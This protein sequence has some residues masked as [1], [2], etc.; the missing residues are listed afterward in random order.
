MNRARSS[1]L[2]VGSALIVAACTGSQSGAPA[3][4][5]TEAP[6]STTSLQAPPKPAPAQYNNDRDKVS[7]D[8]CFELSDEVVTELGYDA[9][10]RDRSD[11]LSNHYAFIG[12]NFD[13]R[14]DVRGQ[15]LVTGSLT[16]HASNITLPE[17]RERE[18]RNAENIRIGARD[19]IRYPAT[20]TCYVVV[21]F[22]EGVLSVQ[23][24]TSTVFVSENPCDRVLPAAEA[25]EATLPA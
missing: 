4:V 20:E 8:P 9:G 2:C 16:V 1:V 10:S 3:T 25:I 19:G 15:K 21:P 5:E 12:C 6:S 13:R 17:Y 23:V 18:G 7:H 14:G 22:R 11:F 24:S